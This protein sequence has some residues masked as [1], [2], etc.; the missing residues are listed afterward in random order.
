M[1]YH[2]N[3]RLCSGV[4]GNFS[5][6]SCVQCFWECPRPCGS[7][8]KQEDAL[9]RKHF[10]PFKPRCLRFDICYVDF[11]QHI[12]PISKSCPDVS[13]WWVRFTRVG[14]NFHLSCAGS[15]AVFCDSETFRTLVKRDKISVV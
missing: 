11:H 10:P 5:F 12:S 15:V 9:Q 2:D 14:L 13:R 4:E 6:A 1:L 8:Q 7:T 3:G